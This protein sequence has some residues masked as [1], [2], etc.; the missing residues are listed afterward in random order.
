MINLNRFILAIIP[1]ILMIQVSLTTVPQP[2]IINVHESIEQLLDLAK[3]QYV[4]S[5]LNIQ[6][7]ILHGI[8]LDF[9][10]YD[11]SAELDIGDVGENHEYLAE[12]SSVYPDQFSFFCAI[13]PDSSERENILATCIEDGAI[14]V[15]FY[16]GYSYA[17]TFN[18]DDPDLQDF[19]EKL[20]E[21]DMPLMLPINTYLYQAELENLLLTQPDLNVICSHFC[22]ASK[23]LDRLDLMMS[24]YDNLYIDTSF[25]Y[26][27]YFIDGM[28]TITANHDDYAAF[29][30]EHQDRILFGTD[31]VVT[32]YED[33]SVEWLTKLYSDYINLMESDTFVSQIDAGNT[34]R[35]LNLPYA[36]LSK[37]F[38]KNWDELLE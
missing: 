3:L 24:S 19:Y 35:G 33:K 27:D 22:L 25:G 28:L 38:W 16:V 6:T 8:P 11:E 20:V 4:M 2:R 10:Y 34:Y 13:D 21:N 15:K 1:L 18:V 12:A 31:V 32:S 7:T 23:D 9:L 30:K 5:G 26:L 37:V 29:F 36:I 17:H 14:G